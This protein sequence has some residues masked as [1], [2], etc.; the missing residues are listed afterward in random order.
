MQEHEQIERFSF[1]N[2][3]VPFTNA[4]AITWVVVIGF[5]VFFNVLFNGLVWDDKIYLINNTDLRTLN[6]GYLFG[7]NTWNNGLY[8]RPLTAVYFS[9]LYSFFNLNPFIYHFLQVVIHI[10]DSALLFFIF[11]KF[12]N[13][14][15][16]FFLSLIFLVHPIQVESVV[17]IS[18]TLSPLSFLFGSIALLLSFRNIVTTKNTFLIFLLLFVSI[19]IKETGVLFFFYVLLYRILFHFKKKEIAFYFIIDV[20]LGLV[21]LFLRYFIGRVSLTTVKGTI[22]PIAGLN[23]FQRLENIPAIIFYY[24]KTFFYPV[25]LAIDQQWIITK[26]TFNAFFLPLLFDTVFF[27]IALS[28]GIYLFKKKHRLFKSFIFFFLWFVLALGFHVQIFPLDMTVADR[29]FYY[30]IAGLLGLIGITI[31]TLKPYYSK[32]KQIYIVSIIFIIFIVIG[33]SLRTIIRNSN[34][35]DEITLYSHDSKI[36]DS[37]NDETNLG[38]DY[39][40]QKEYQLALFHYEKAVSILPTELN[41]YDLGYVYEE[42]GNLQK[43]KEYYTKAL[44]YNKYPADQHRLIINTISSRLAYIR[45]S[46]P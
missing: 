34:W 4:K 31:I 16:S 6:L 14:Q 12:I 17:F 40:V 8:Y 1:K 23:F 2:Y 37:M 3:F 20:L 22:V 33:L 27:L 43:A 38:S 18:A 10:T 45:Q 42:T 44:T 24:L 5:T 21:Y 29:F 9:L 46:I 41:L 25:S 15:L 35:H 30:P 32:Y 26:V 19:L 39:E 28:L 13:K 7:P 36:Y 11:K